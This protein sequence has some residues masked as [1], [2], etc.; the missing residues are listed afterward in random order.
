MGTAVRTSCSGFV[1]VDESRLSSQK[2]RPSR[3]SSP[4]CP[5]TERIPKMDREIEKLEQFIA[6]MEGIRVLMEQEEALGRKIERKK[7]ELG[8]ETTEQ[9]MKSPA[10]RLLIMQSSRVI[11]HVDYL[12]TLAFEACD[13]AEEENV[14][15][16]IVAE[17]RGALIKAKSL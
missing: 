8:I 17:L 11:N 16:E 7:T 12:F 5:V 15:P 2:S 10:G 3:P 1:G 13:A 4:G 14:A 6:I 9:A